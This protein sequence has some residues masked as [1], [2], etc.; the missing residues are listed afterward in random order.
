MFFHITQM[1]A[2]G[3]VQLR[4]GHWRDAP[5]NLGATIASSA[6]IRGAQRRQLQRMLG[7]LLRMGGIVSLLVLLHE[8][9]RPIPLA[10]LR[11]FQILLVG[12]LKTGEVGEH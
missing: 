7:R 8:H 11:T 9:R 2:N 5:A 4:R 6:A 3:E 10:T 1:A 12:E